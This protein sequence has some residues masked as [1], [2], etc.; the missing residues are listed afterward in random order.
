MSERA[1]EGKKRDAEA[2]L[3][4]TKTMNMSERKMKSKLVSIKTWEC[5]N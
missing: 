2:E 4:Q 5:I 3:G 1:Y